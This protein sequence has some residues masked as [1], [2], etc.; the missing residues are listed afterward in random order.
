VG[1][2][3][4]LLA[5]MLFFAFGSALFLVMGTHD[6]AGIALVPAQ[7]GRES[8]QS[9][10][11]TEAQVRGLADG[12][13]AD[14]QDVLAAWLRPGFE[15]RSVVA[16]KDPGACLFELGLASPRVTRD[17]YV[18][19]WE[20]RLLVDGESVEMPGVDGDV[21]LVP[22][23]E[24]GS[25][26]QRVYPLQDVLGDA[27]SRDALGVRPVLTMRVGRRGPG[28]VTQ[29][30]HPD[31]TLTWTG[32]E[33]TL[34]VYD[35]YP[36]D[37]PEV[38]SDPQ[39]DVVMAGLLRPRHVRYERGAGLAG[40]RRL[41]MVL[42]YEPAPRGPVP[43][44]MDVSLAP[45]DG[46]EALGLA[47]LTTSARAKLPEGETFSATLDFELSEPPSAAEQR[48][49]LALEAGSLKAVRLLMR[50]SRDAALAQ[51][52]FDSYWGGTLDITVPVWPHVPQGD[53]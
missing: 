24:G 8:L 50:P 3:F 7:D 42:V 40:A 41:R 12:T 9:V 20:C 4:L 27:L 17:G 5:T 52:G 34:F 48:V 38:V 51:P 45:A 30:V 22:E 14:G 29:V 2:G 25:W 15:I 23:A 26:Y 43:V 44:A 36:A 16:R 32:P 28:G 53:G 47:V 35:E 13:Q 46:G 37:F 10:P 49:L 18:L 21:P 6:S 33:R 19:T 31:T 11:P 1:C 39:T